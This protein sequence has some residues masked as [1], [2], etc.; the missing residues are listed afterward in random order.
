MFSPPHI[1]QILL[2]GNVCY[3]DHKWWCV[4]RV[5]AS[6]P[7]PDANEG[8]LPGSTAA[9]ISEAPP[10]TF[11]YRLITGYLSG[12][13]NALCGFLLWGGSFSCYSSPGVFCACV[14]VLFLCLKIKQKYSLASKARIFVSSSNSDS[15]IRLICVHRGH[16]ALWLPRDFQCPEFRCV[17]LRRGGEYFY[18]SACM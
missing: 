7:A 10:C 15:F 4:R 16:F 2:M 14:C 17:T 18:S 11:F 9:D 8:P 3:C 12:A 5:C 1:L 13:K 6:L